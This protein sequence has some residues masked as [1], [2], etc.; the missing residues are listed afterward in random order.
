MLSL[1]PEV[2]ELRRRAREFCTKLKEMKVPEDKVP[3][4]MGEEGFLQYLVPKKYGGVYET[5]KVLPLCVI[6]ETFAQ[7]YLPL[8]SI[9]TVMGL[10]SMPIVI[11]G[12]EEQK[13]R[14][15]PRIASGEI[16]S[17][18]A[19]TEP[20]AGSDLGGIETIYKRDGGEFII[21]GTK[22]FVSRAEFAD[23]IVVLAKS[24]RSRGTK[25]ISAFIVE[26]GTK[27]MRIERMESMVDEVLNIITFDDCRIPAENLIGKEGDGFSIAMRNLNIFRTTVASHAIGVAQ[28]AID[29][30]IRYSMK[31]KLFGE[32]LINFQETKFKIADM[33][34]KLF[35]MRYMTYATARA[36]DENSEDG[37]L[38]ASMSKL[39]CTET[40]QDIVDKALQIL[41]GYGLLKDYPL[42]KLF[43]DIRSARIY[44]GTS[45]VQ[46]LI[47][48]R[49]VLKRFEEGKG[50]W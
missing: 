1:S 4:L 6:R 44:E 43:R 32:L 2:E 8:S 11:A 41:G 38:L 21:N 40:A 27:G 5:V 24:D 34:T 45:E 10:G 14:Y 39:F 48:S 29:T 37:P 31:R 19:A 36:L 33:V 23:F 25:N 9:F 22:N 7:H 18:F 47:I 30:A 12:S 46:K 28:A 17:A 26:K 49:F 20:S 16:A 3:R 50:L 42:E 13:L 35:A 15:L